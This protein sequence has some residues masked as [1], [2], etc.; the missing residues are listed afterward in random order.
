MW[1]VAYNVST[2]I[3]VAWAMGETNVTG[4]SGVDGHEIVLVERIPP[5]DL[6]LNILVYDGQEIIVQ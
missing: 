1:E 3:V 6:E 4:W 5:H 2:G